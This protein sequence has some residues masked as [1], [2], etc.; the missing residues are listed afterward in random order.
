MNF[1]ARRPPKD[2]VMSSKRIKRGGGNK[3]ILL[4]S[5]C[6]PALQV[7]RVSQQ[8]LYTY[9]RDK[10]SES[11]ETPATKAQMGRERET[12]WQ[13]VDGRRPR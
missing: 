12:L 13:Q 3:S 5:F 10:H 6:P 2:S 11:E 7:P 9:Y 4:T 1:T 8:P